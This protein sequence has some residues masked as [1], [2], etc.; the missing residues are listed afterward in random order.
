MISN[1]Y[2]VKKLVI[3][4]TVI[5][6]FLL[7]MFFMRRALKLKYWYDNYSRGN[8]HAFAWRAENILFCQKLRL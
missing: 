2:L 1:K 8:K 3:K 5:Y 4:D 6:L 7:S